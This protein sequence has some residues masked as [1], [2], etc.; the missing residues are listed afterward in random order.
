MRKP[1]KIDD[2]IVRLVTAQTVQNFV[3][4]PFYLWNEGCTDEELDKLIQYLKLKDI[5]VPNIPEDDRKESVKRAIYLIWAS[6]ECNNGIC[7]L[8]GCQE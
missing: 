5:P 8:M 2:P 4:N 1:K 3:D 7:T 6:L